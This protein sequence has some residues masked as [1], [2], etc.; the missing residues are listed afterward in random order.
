MK[1]NE[2][3]NAIGWHPRWQFYMFNP[4]SYLEAIGK[5]RKSNLR[6]A[7]EHAVIEHVNIEES[8]DS[9]EES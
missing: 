6:P 8:E 7:E 1:L 3:P 9:D 4:G 5:K 2:V